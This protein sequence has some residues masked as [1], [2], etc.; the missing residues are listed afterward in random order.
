MEPQAA[1][2]AG[3]CAAG[4]KFCALFSGN[5]APKSC[6]YSA[7]IRIRICP[8]RGTILAHSAAQRG[9]LRVRR[10][11]DLTARS[12]NRCEPAKPP[13]PAPATGLQFDRQLRY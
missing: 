7:R 12:E 10:E 1:A 9:S 13:P 6:R 5:A 4:L 2:K 3:G 8:A 11:I